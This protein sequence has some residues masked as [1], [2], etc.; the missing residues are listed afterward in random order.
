MTGIDYVDLNVRLPLQWVFIGACFVAAVFAIQGRW[1][2][3]LLLPA[4]RL[5]EV[6]APAYLEVRRLILL[7]VGDTSNEIAPDWISLGGV[8]LGQIQ[9]RKAKVASLIV[10]VA[11]TGDKSTGQI[12]ANLAMGA[13][14]SRSII[15]KTI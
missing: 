4:V 14:L 3:L 15:A 8:A 13:L 7:G 5:I 1:R 2:V 12:A 11:A 10:D 6:L 9:T